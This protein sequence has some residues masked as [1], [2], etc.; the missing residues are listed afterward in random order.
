VDA[1]ARDARG[2]QALS[3][4]SDTT[5]E[6]EQLEVRLIAIRQLLRTQEAYLKQTADAG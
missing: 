1:R 6:E 5:P 3:P 4:F 2:S